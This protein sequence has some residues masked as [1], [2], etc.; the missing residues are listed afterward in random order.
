MKE[1]NIAWMNKDG[2]SVFNFGLCSDRLLCTRTIYSLNF[3]RKI[4]ECMMTTCFP[5]LRKGISKLLHEITST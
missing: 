1:E 2:K 5:N 4:S 3:L